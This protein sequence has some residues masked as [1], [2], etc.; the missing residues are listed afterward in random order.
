MEFKEEI[1]SRNMGNMLAG[2]IVV[3]AGILLLARQMGVK[4]PGWLFGW[5]MMLIAIGFFIGAKNN[6]KDF[7]W[8]IVAGI[9]A[10]FLVD[11]LVP[12]LYNY[13]WPTV[14]IGA[15][16]YIILRSGKNSKKIKPAVIAD[17][18]TSELLD[19]AAVFGVV[20]KQ[21]LSKDFRGGE[22]VSVFGGSEINLLQADFTG[23]IKLEVVSVFGGTKL[24]IPTNWEVRSEAAAVFGGIEDKRDKN[25]IPDPNKV[26]ILDG[27]AVFGGIEITNR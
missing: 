3:G 27:T 21:V 23:P 19:V 8:L 20:Q 14:I 22:V 7:G 17:E 13:I 2:M 5:E 9:G 10:I 15:G 16:L 26:L 6:F 1:K 18:S 12:S 4:L 24:V 11:D 25:V